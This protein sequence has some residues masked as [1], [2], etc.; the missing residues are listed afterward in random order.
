MVFENLKKKYV[1]FTLSH[2]AEER[3]VIKVGDVIGSQPIRILFSGAFSHSTEQLN[4]TLCVFCT[5]FQIDAVFSLL[6]SKEFTLNYVHE[7]YQ[8]NSGLN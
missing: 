8:R 1:N 5:C 6:Y 3:C 2:N 4:F 7:M